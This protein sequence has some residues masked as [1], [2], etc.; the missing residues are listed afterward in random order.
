MYSDCGTSVGHPSSL[1][2]NAKISVSDGDRTKADSLT[3]D[4][5]DPP[6]CVNDLNESIKQLK[7]DAIE[8][9][10]RASAK[11]PVAPKL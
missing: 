11:A 9:Y 10:K 8:A 6:A 7:P 3:V 4:L 5:W 2:I 1:L